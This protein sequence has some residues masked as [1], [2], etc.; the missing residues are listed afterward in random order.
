[1]QKYQATQSQPGTADR[2]RKCFLIPGSHVQRDHG[3]LILHTMQI[4]TGYVQ[5]QICM[6]T[7]K[8]TRRNIR[9]LC[10]S[11]VTD[12]LRQSIFEYGALSADEYREIH[13]HGLDVVG[14]MFAFTRG[15]RRRT[16]LFG[17]VVP[18]KKLKGRK[19]KAGRGVLGRSGSNP[20]ALPP[21][22]EKF[23]VILLKRS[24]F[25]KK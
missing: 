25:W 1:M 13:V 7:I 11:I 14:H 16:I 22:L 5:C 4:L 21:P 10:A 18:K 17:T 9:V 15:W 19:K 3:D 6:V 8:K 23:E 12:G 24:G 20:D 2:P